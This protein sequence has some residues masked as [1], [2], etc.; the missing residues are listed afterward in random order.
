MSEVVQ[1]GSPRPQTAAQVPCGLSGRP[2]T[3]VFW[4]QV[5]TL[6]WMLAECGASLYAAGTA[7]SPAI[8]AI[9][10]ECKYS[11]IKLYLHS[12]PIA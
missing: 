7:R 5:I 6:T 2:T 4:L 3:A 10:A 12:A 11:S 8:F 9:G 1:L